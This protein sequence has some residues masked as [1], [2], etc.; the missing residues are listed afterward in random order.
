VAYFSLNL[1]WVELASCFVIHKV[2]RSW[3]SE[4]ENVLML[5]PRYTKLALRG[6]FTTQIINSRK[7]VF[8]VE[9]MTEL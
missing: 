4:K 1:F 5:R 2:L 3:L 7:V 9:R 8:I 6:D